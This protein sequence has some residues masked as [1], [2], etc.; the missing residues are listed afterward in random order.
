[1]ALT[2]AQYDEILREYDRKQSEDRLALKERREEVYGKDRR[3]AEIDGS[4]AD[5]AFRQAEKLLSGDSEALTTLRKEVGSLRNEKDEI[6]KSLGYQ[7]EYLSL[8]VQCP[9]CKDTGYVNG[10]R[11]HCFEQAAIDLI[12][13][14][15]NLSTVL[16]RENFEHFSLDYYSKENQNENGLSSYDAAVLAVNE[17]HEFIDTFNTEFRNLFFYGNTG[18]GKTFLSNCIAKA[19]LDAGHS[20]VYFTAPQLFDILEKDVFEKDGAARELHRNIYE[21]E[22]LIID[23]LGTEV[24]NRF[25]TTQFLRTLNERMQRERS[26]IISTNL[27][28]SDVEDLYTERSLS[29][30]LGYYTVIR[31]FGDDIRL[32]QKLKKR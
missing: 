7:A 23:D 5:L 29:R 32:L 10:K 17:C 15:S 19:L 1:M 16:A 6:L 14:Q 13:T 26:T 22:L 21:V 8:P 24:N 30:I 31:L 3:L 27:A 9:D 20:V 2:N 28:M 4:I 12:Y 11:C 25:T 18:V